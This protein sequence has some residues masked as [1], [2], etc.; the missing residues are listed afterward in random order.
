MMDTLLDDENARANAG[1]ERLQS[2]NCV[3]P[4][5]AQRHMAEHVTVMEE[6]ETLYSFMLLKAGRPAPL[7][8]FSPS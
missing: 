2:P 1:M 8:V 7:S 5:I 4:S 6:S 3:P